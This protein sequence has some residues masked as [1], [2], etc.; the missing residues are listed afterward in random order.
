[1]SGLNPGYQVKVSL[2]RA[3]PADV[4]TISLSMKRMLLAESV[5]SRFEIDLP[6]TD[7]GFY[8]MLLIRRARELATTL[9]H[10]KEK[11]ERMIDQH[12]L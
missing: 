8:N 11:G 6:P 4:A 3:I 9:I 10:I 1:L 2:Y 12:S 5:S 7:R